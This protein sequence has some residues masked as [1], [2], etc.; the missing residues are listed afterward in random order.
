MQRYASAPFKELLTTWRVRRHLTQTA[1]A[2]ALGTHRNTIGRG[3]RGAGLPETRGMVLEL[4]R[5]LRLEEWET[6]QLLQAS[7]T[8]LAASPSTGWSRHSSRIR[9]SLE[10]RACG[11]SGRYTRCMPFFP[12]EPHT[13]SQCERRV[14]QVLACR[15]RVPMLSPCSS[16][17]SRFGY[18]S[19]SQ[20]ILRLPM[21]NSLT[22]LY[23][24]PGKDE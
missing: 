12:W 6:C 10:R 18:S 16:K 14:L 23:Q 17:L 22:T 4:A 11:A 8:A 21:L 9:W 13:W 3:E 20:H 7:L 24:E 15:E 5:M 1:L 19:W 2:T